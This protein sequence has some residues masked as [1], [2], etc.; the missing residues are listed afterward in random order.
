[1]S[2]T[3]KSVVQRFGSHLSIAG[4]LHLALERAQA[5]GCDCLQVFVKN[6]KQWVGKPLTDE[7]VRLFR[8][9]QRETGIKP[10]VAHAS[11]LINLGSP[12]DAMWNRGI[13]AVVDELQRC[14]ALGIRGLVLHPGAHM[15]EGEEAGLTR[16]AA[17]LDDVHRRAPGLAAKVLLETTA[18]QG[19]ALGWRVEH[20][21]SILQRVAAPDRL[22]VCLD[23]CHLFAAGYDLRDAAA[24]DQLVGALKRHVTL[25]RVACIHV[26]DSKTP[27]ASRVDRHTH[28][29]DGHIG[30]DGFRNI[31]RDTRLARAPRI[32]ETPKGENDQGED[33]DAV[34]LR[35]LRGYVRPERPRPKSVSARRGPQNH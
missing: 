5:V 24:C 10:V 30:A 7:D 32:L 20:L 19:T 4:G 21:G 33:F 22:G 12:D 27:L 8:R 11:Y 25:R 6:Q 28:I 26:N 13:A 3:T 14:E 35:T 15:G 23:T 17:G 31:L 1:M 29:G 9:A 18:G 16:I 34:N 2:S